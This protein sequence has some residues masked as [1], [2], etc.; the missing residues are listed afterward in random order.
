MF[1]FLD[2]V[3]VDL[4]NSVTNT[5][6]KRRVF[7]DLEGSLTTEGDILQLAMIETD[8]SFNIANVF[9]MY[10]KNRKPILDEE[11]NVHGITEEFLKDNA[12]AHFTEMLDA[13]PFKS[14]KDTMFISYTTFDVRRVND[15][16]R[17]YNLP[18][19]DFGSKV[20]DLAST[21]LDGTNS[22]FDAFN[23]GKKKGDLLAKELGE[24][25]FNQVFKE[26][27]QF[28]NFTNKGN[29]DALFDTV[30]ILALCRGLTDE[31]LK[32]TD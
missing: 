17:S 16:L 14:S 31:K 20:S 5:E 6:N 21:P 24:E 27:E 11:I 10:F 13:M 1:D 8:W 15:E 7:F 2:V 28:G 19:I 12:K 4:N 9:N 32:R 25:V 22:H 18:L 29:H 3:H 30:M 23:L 26:L